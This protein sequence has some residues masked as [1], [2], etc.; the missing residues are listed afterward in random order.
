MRSITATPNGFGSVRMQSAGGVSVTSF[1]M[2]SL[3]AA[4]RQMYGLDKISFSDLVKCVEK[5]DSA[6]AKLLAE[7]GCKPHHCTLAKDEAL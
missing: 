1:P 3:V 5:I 6:T 4:V 2:S 7:A